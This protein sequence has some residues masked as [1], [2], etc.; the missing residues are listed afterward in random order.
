[1]R[2]G[3]YNGEAYVYEDTEYDD[4]YVE[5]RVVFTD[6]TA[7]DESYF[8][9]GFDDVTE[10]MDDFIMEMEDLYPEIFEEM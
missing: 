8:E 10:A 7:I 2:K 4:T 5:W 1:M 9:E 6:G 3:G